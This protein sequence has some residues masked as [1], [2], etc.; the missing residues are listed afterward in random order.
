MIPRSTT[1][2][3]IAVL[4][5]LA[6]HF[7]GLGFTWK[8]Q[9]QP[10][11]GRTS[12]EVVALG[13]AFEDVAEAMSEAVKP[14]PAPAPEPEPEPPVEAVTAPEPAD[15]PTSQALVASANPQAVSAP[16]TGTAQIVQPETTEP[17]APDTSETPEPATQ[18]PVGAEESAVTDARLA[19][20][21]GTA[22]VTAVPQGQPSG[23]EEPSGAP[24]QNS[25]VSTPT[26][27]PSAPVPVPPVAVT[28]V[29]PSV[30]VVSLEPAEIEPEAPPATFEPEPEP[31]QESSEAP[32][33]GPSGLAV[34][35]SLRPLLRPERPSSEPDGIPDGS[36]EQDFARLA[37]SQLI[38]SPLTA[39]KRDGT[40]VFGGQGGR[41]RSAGQGF[42]SSR[43]PGNSDVTNYAGLV[44]VHLN[45][46]P[47]VAVSGRGWARV[48]FN[49]SP[50]GTL[51]SVDII[52]SSGSEEI[53]RAAKQQVRSAVPFPRPPDGK[54]K[55]LNFVYR[56]D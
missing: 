5:S 46:T 29:T 18:S 45:R 6:V 40:N 11:V 36:S 12:S 43:G 2:A 52:D 48:F 53:G 56:I 26:D 19:P 17:P 33:A 13:N 31:S 7:L 16:D 24:A 8:V 50:D 47:P 44:L 54:N 3:A 15:A 28:S 23:G 9:P 38:E 20:P 35:T 49:I 10:S 4:L 39:Y 25:A 42:Q 22:S 21:P 27:L 37:P 55:I 14:E 51:A 34:A 32:E 41:A 1:I 30:P